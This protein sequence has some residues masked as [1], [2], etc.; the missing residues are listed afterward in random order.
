MTAPEL[1][2]LPDVELEEH[3]AEQKEELFHLRFQLVTGQ[4][5]NPQR[6]R[7][8]KREIARCLTVL[9]ERDLAAE[10]ARQDRAR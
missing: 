5:D 1:R 6:V 3:L 9:R 8:V 2:E 4:L 7:Q 10:Q